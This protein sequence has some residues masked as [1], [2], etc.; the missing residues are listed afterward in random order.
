MTRSSQP[1]EERRER[2]FSR[3]GDDTAKPVCCSSSQSVAAAADG[4]PAA[5]APWADWLRPN[6]G[7]RGGH[8]GESCFLDG[9]A[10]PLECSQLHSAVFIPLLRLASQSF[11]TSAEKTPNKAASGQDI[12]G[13]PYFP[14]IAF[15]LGSVI[16][17]Q[18][19]TAG[20]LCP[21]LSVEWGS[22]Q[23]AHCVPCAAKPPASISLAG[24]AACVCLLSTLP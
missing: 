12:R 20:P 1:H 15:K 9:H 13:I 24:G 7:Y 14:V 19:H 4:L 2:C 18:A 23:A 6:G 8:V 3:G 11:F 16:M 22:G 17:G 5:R 10:G 21:W